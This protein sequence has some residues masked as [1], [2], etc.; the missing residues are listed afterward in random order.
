MTLI[1][2]TAILSDAGLVRAN[3]EDTALAGERLV[4]VAD[5]MGGLPAG[6]VASEIV[7]R[8]L[9]DLPLPGTPEDAPAVLRAAI[10][11]ANQ[12]IRAAIG[13]DPAREG[14]GTT[15]TAGLLAADRLTIAQVGDS[16][17][18]LLRQGVLRQL[19]RDDTFVQA[20]VDQGALT[21][22]EAR[23][24]PQRSLIT[25][26]VQGEDRPPA[27][28][29]LAV[30][31]GDRL[32]LCSDG[33]SDYVEDLAIGTALASYP[34]RQQCVEQLVKLAHQAGAP[35]NVTVVVADV[36]LVGATR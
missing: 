21:L 22:E 27:I 16:R 33:L 8:I 13:S 12:R 30:V 10:S 17:C 20:L 34:D 29:V 1:L 9:H 23:R 14:M 4:A 24:H 36:D 6:E 19:T 31:P 11:V 35:D 5:G 7:I 25:Q 15:L 2:R 32:L 3:N 26:A 28:G 18:Y